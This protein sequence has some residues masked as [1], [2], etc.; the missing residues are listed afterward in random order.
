MMRFKERPLVLLVLLT[1]LH[2]GF[3][4]HRNNDDLNNRELTDVSQSSQKDGLTRGPHYPGPKVPG[5]PISHLMDLSVLDPYNIMSGKSFESKETASLV[6]QIIPLKPTLVSALSQGVKPENRGESKDMSESKNSGFISEKTKPESSRKT[7][8]FEDKKLIRKKPKTQNLP[9]FHGALEEEWPLTDDADESVEYAGEITSG[10]G[11]RKSGR[12]AH[13]KNKNLFAKVERG[14]NTL[15]HEAVRKLLGFSETPPALGEESRYLPDPRRERRLPRYVKDLYKRFQSGEIGAASLAK[16]NTVRSIHTSVGSVKGQPMFLFNVSSVR[17]SEQLLSA[18]IHLYKRRL[19]RWTRS[20]GVELVL[21]QVAPHFLSEI[22]KITVLEASRPG[23]QWYDV[24]TAV[25]SCLAG[26]ELRKPF[27]FGLSFRFSRGNKMRPLPLKKF[28]RHHSM[29]FLVVYSNE[30]EAVNFEQLDHLAGRLFPQ[31]KGGKLHEE[32][33]NTTERNVLNQNNGEDFNINSNRNVHDSRGRNENKTKSEHGEK[34]RVVAVAPDFEPSTEGLVPSDPRDIDRSPKTSGSHNTDPGTLKPAVL[35][36]FEN[37]NKVLK[38]SHIRKR[39][40]RTNEIPQDPKDYENYLKRQKKLQSK[41]QPS[42]T[43]ARKASRHKLASKDENK[44]RLL[45]SP[46]EYAKYQKRQKQEDE[47][48][49]RK[50]RR[51]RKKKHRSRY[52]SNSSQ[53]ELKTPSEWDSS[54]MDKSRSPPL[55]RSGEAQSASEDAALCGRRKLVVDFADIGWEDWIISPKSF[56][57]H[58][59]AGECPFPLTK[60]L[61]PSNH[62]TIQSIVH[63]VGIYA[64]VPAPCCVPDQMS[65]ITLLYFD[66]AKNVV[67]KNYPGMTVDSCAC[68]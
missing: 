4:R 18:E 19:R 41:Q 68:R 39:S 10:A 65:P 44:T 46:D 43:R 63:A 58:Y 60:R 35:H 26:R 49:R 56:Q 24:T 7:A 45:P 27:V 47:R 21:Y 9:I 57:A 20:P 51:K 6:Q 32:D 40:L 34:P 42:V 37:R 15:L 67:L 11:S 33:T 31:N 2:L 3:C 1:Q 22:G 25:G 50:N 28:G 38:H 29:P 52:L 54:S 30:T 59:C 12:K 14:R 16:G 5:I 55:G 53:H 61:R 13:R 23:W 17:P 48:R 62:A 8:L 66:E 36:H 64:Q